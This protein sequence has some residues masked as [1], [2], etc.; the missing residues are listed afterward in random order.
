LTAPHTNDDRKWRQK[1]GRE[2]GT[3]FTSVAEEDEE[4]D[5][6]NKVKKTPNGPASG[7]QDAGAAGKYHPV[8]S[9]A[10]R[11]KTA[12]TTTTAAASTEDTSTCSGTN[13]SRQKRQRKQVARFDDIYANN[14]EERLLQQAI[15]N[16]LKET[17]RFKSEIPDAP[18]FYPTIEEFKNPLAY[19]KK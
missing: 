4:G 11:K 5:T 17:A 3:N 13:S 18:V 15:K 12:I 7:E 6:T 9:T 2:S 8:R 19:I 10:T 1:R 14:E 16:S